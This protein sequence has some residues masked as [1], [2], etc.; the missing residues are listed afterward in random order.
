MTAADLTGTWVWLAVVLIV[1]LAVV[2]WT[3]RRD[4][5]ER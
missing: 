3:D 5:G 2:L 1:A 4:G